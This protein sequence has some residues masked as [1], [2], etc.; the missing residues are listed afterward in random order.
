MEATRTRSQP[1]VPLTPAV[2][3]ILL[4]LSDGEKHGYAI[5]LEV[6]ENTQGEVKMGPGTLY[7][8]IKRMLETGLIEESGERP[9]PEMDDQRRRY[10]RLTGIGNKA[11]KTEADRLAR[12]VS[13]AHLKQVLEFTG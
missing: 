8:S 11:L 10:Y 12:Q 3:N 1:Q 9:D 7:G 13:I 6:E 4:A 2:F 5:M